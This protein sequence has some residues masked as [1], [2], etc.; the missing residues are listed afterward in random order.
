MATGISLRVRKNNNKIFAIEEEEKRMLAVTLKQW[1][2]EKT[3]KKTEQHSANLHLWQFI[4]ARMW[5]NFLGRKIFSS[6]ELS[7]CIYYIK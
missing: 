1:N 6:I 5:S 7:I 2:G 4:D 3:N